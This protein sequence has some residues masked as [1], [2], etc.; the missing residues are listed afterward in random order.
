M[1][2]R[3]AIAASGVV[4][5]LALAGA[6]VLTAP[7]SHASPATPGKLSVSIS[8]LPRH[9]ALALGGRSLTFVVTVRNGTRQVERGIT[10]VVA[11]DH[12]SCVSTPVRMAPLG[13]LQEL[14]RATG[15]WHTVTYD[16]IGGGMD[17]VMLYQVPPFT[18]AP[19]AAASFTFRVSLDR[20]SA[21]PIK[22]HA[23]SMGLDASVVRI[24][25]NWNSQVVLASAE[26]SVAVLTR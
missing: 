10:P 25:I 20:A 19:G 7:A 2:N 24:P 1:L 11:M 16:R 6:A 8:G 22:V 4:C 18:L 26:D 21:Q 13:T 9:P 14:N 17:Y 3:I 15:K 12:C 23:G 5:G